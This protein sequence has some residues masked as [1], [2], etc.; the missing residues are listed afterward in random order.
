MDGF[1]KVSTAVTIKLG[2]YVDAT[3]GV[4]VE[5][6][7]TITQSDVRLTKN[8]GDFA[9]K[10]DA[11]ACTH[12]EGGWY[13]CPLNTTDTNTLGLLKIDA[14]MAGACPVWLTFMVVTANVYNTFCSSDMLDVDISAASGTL[15]GTLTYMEALRLMLAVL[16][17][18]LSGGGSGQL[19]FRDS[20]DST[21]RVVMTVTSS[22]NRTTVTLDGS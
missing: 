6:G 22:K 9:Q 17:G 19:T 11:T 1:L 16:T 12:D 10:N 3:D 7:L 13:D 20:T 5:A 4:T 18:K 8:G 14:S 2:K 21:D 15:E